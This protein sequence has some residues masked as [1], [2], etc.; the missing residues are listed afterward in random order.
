[1]KGVYIVHTYISSPEYTLLVLY[2]HNCKRSFVVFEITCATYHGC[3]GIGPMHYLMLPVLCNSERGEARNMREGC[4]WEENGALFI[5]YVA[6]L[7]L[8]GAPGIIWGLDPVLV[9]SVILVVISRHHYLMLCHLS[10]DV[11]FPLHAIMKFVY[12]IGLNNTRNVL[13]CRE[14]VR[15]FE[16]NEISLNGE[17]MIKCSRSIFDV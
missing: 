17:H 15:H 16:G 4:H 9:T 10:F 2:F 13:R 11:F 14:H 1:M 12:T 6:W 8:S 3:F 5:V 7:T